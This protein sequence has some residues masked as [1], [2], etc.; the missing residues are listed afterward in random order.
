MTQPRGI[1]GDFL[2]KRRIFSERYM[3]AITRSFLAAAT[4]ASVSVLSD[5]RPAQADFL[6][7]LKATFTPKQQEPEAP[8]PKLTLKEYIKQN[9]PPAGAVRL[10]P[11]SVTRILVDA[12]RRKI[13]VMGYKSN[14]ENE[15]LLTTIDGFKIGP[16]DTTTGEQFGKTRHG[17]MKTPYGTYPLTKNGGSKFVLALKIG[18]PTEAQRAKGYTGG[19]VEIHGGYPQGFDPASAPDW[20]NGCMALPDWLV[21]QLF[22]ATRPEATITIAPTLTPTPILIAK[23]I[24]PPKLGPA[25]EPPVIVAS[26]PQTVLSDAVASRPPISVADF[27][28]Y[29]SGQPYSTF[30]QFYYTPPQP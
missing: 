16:G 7:I 8:A 27:R 14:A 3:K 29:F 13:F 10:Q 1:F 24:T 4:F 6:D 2:F 23:K 25:Q 30:G 22:Y 18:Y 11:N 9:Q 21:I 12:G 20:T 15:T 17:D 19:D 28:L 5:P 26:N